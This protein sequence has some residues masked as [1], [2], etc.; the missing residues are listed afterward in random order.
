[1][2]QQI[3]NLEEENE[4]LRDELDEIR[5]QLSGLVELVING[6]PFELEAIGPGPDYARDTEIFNARMSRFS[7]E[8]EGSK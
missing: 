3:T 6:Q 8:Y 2:T 5:E 4:I 1:M 7:N